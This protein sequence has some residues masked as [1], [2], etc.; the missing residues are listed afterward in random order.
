ME[1]GQ[2]CSRDAERQENLTE[3]LGKPGRDTGQTLQRDRE[4]LERGTTWDMGYEEPVRHPILM[5][6]VYV[7]CINWQALASGIKITQP[8]LQNK[9]LASV[10]ARSATD[11]NGKRAS[12]GA[13]QT[14]KNTWRK[15]YYKC[16]K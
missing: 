14:M 6:G 12:K 13:L 7:Y 1:T 11:V 10:F 4:S 8:L 15:M 3:K 9:S 2:T 16:L 5:L